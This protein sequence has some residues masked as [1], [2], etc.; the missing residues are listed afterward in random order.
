MLEDNFV[1]S[2]VDKS[3]VDNGCSRED[4]ARVVDGKL[5]I[6]N[7]VL[8]DNEILEI[9]KEIVVDVNVVDFVADVVG[10]E[11]ALEENISV[12]DMA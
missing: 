8:V 10:H 2:M 5:V 11:D 7:G 12:N 1:F 6:A 3:K 9:M 4:D